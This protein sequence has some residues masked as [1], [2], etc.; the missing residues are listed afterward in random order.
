MSQS[1]LLFPIEQRCSYSKVERFAVQNHGYALE[2]IHDRN[3]NVLVGLMYTP[4]LRTLCMDAIQGHFNTYDQSTT[5]FTLRR[6]KFENA[7]ITGHF[8]LVVTRM[9]TLKSCWTHYVY[10]TTLVV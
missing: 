3:R 5:Q 1:L 10:Y 8:G 7:T 6:S 2:P 9:D 4:D